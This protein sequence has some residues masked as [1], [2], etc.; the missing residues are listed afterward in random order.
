MLDVLSLALAESRSQ[1]DDSPERENQITVY[2]ATLKSIDGDDGS[3]GFS[4]LADTL[5]EALCVMFCLSVSGTAC[6]WP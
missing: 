3:N 5:S 1:D 2:T 6:C 4:R